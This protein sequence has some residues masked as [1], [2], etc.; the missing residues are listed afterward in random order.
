MKQR[1]LKTVNALMLSLFAS[2]ITYAYPLSTAKT[3]R[4][5]ISAHNLFCHPHITPPETLLYAPEVLSQYTKEKH[6]HAFLE[7]E[8]SQCGK[9]SQ[10]LSLSAE[11]GGSVEFSFSL[12]SGSTIVCD[13]FGHHCVSRPTEILT[14][15][16]GGNI[17]LK[18]ETVS[19]TLD[20]LSSIARENGKHRTEIDWGTFQVRVAD[21]NFRCDGE[22]EAPN[23]FEFFLM[24]RLISKNEFRSAH[25]GIKLEH[26]FAYYFTDESEDTCEYKRQVLDLASEHGGYIDV[27]L[28]TSDASYRKYTSISEYGVSS[29]VEEVKETLRVGLP[30]GLNVTSKGETT[31]RL[32]FGEC[33]ME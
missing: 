15:V 9:R 26:H 10:L 22:S 28:I 30:I 6:T 33:P 17:S 4:I 1:T 14:L 13:E 12:R 31:K 32:H 27:R 23:M 7:D 24:P 8:D 3:L 2:G 29:C 18:S 20:E 11:Q 16:T 25:T 21:Q 5:P 19:S